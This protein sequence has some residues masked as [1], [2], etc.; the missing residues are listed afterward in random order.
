MRPIRRT[1]GVVGMLLCVLVFE[2]GVTA[3][4]EVDPVSATPPS[5]AQDHGG[6]LAA[7]QPAVWWP[8]D[9]DHGQKAERGGT[10]SDLTQYSPGGAG[11][12]SGPVPGTTGVQLATSAGPGCSASTS[13]P[14]LAASALPASLAAT[15]TFSFEFWIHPAYADDT[16]P[17]FK[18]STAFYVG[19]FFIGLGETGGAAMAGADSTHNT[20]ASNS[21]FTADANVPWHNV[22]GVVTDSSI[23]LYVDGGFVASAPDTGSGRVVT[24]DFGRINQ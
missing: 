6:T 5:V 9:T 15:Q 16:Q 18:A 2:M 12:V 8:L 23:S 24:A 14:Q 17:G 4:V 11:S 22:V 13:A 20:Q 21:S 3:V 19:G 7:L 10:A 1:F